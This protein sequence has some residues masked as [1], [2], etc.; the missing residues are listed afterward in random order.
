[1]GELVSEALHRFHR[2]IVRVA[3]AE[4]DFVLW[5]ILQ[6]M[7][8]K[9]LVDF[10]VFPFE[11]LEN[12]NWGKFLGAGL[13]QSGGLVLIFQVGTR[14]P[15]AGEVEG[16]P[17]QAG[18]TGDCFDEFCEWMRHSLARSPAEYSLS[19]SRAPRP[20]HIIKVVGSRTGRSPRPFW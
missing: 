6:T 12:R 9:A 4:D 19:G 16:D 14:A 11:R 20:S 3:D 15:E 10:R 1:M 13:S 5:I 2:R 8:P 7:A 17:S 18:K